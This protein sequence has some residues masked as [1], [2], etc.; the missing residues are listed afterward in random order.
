MNFLELPGIV[1][2]TIVQN[3][4][5][6]AFLSSMPIVPGHTL[7]APKRIVKTLAELTDDERDACFKIIDEVKKK[8]THVF[9]C[10]GFNIAWNEGTSAGQTVEHLHIHIVPRK[11]GDTGITE[12]EPRKF[13]YRPGSRKSSPQDELNKIALLLRHTV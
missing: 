4:M 10:T 6:F 13:L 3:N 12:Y 7:V 1:E 2:R 5:A 11:E 9:Q 8:L